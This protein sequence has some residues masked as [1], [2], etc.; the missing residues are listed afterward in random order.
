MNSSPTAAS[1]E[2]AYEAPAW[3]R[4][5]QRYTDHLVCDFLGGPRPWKFAWVINFQKAGTFV[6][7]LALIAYYDNTS[8]LGFLYS[9]AVRTWATPQDWTFNDVNTLVVH[10]RGDPVAFVETAP[11]AITISGAGEDIWDVADEFAYA[12]KSLNGD[13]T[14]IARI[15]SLIDTHVN[16]KAGLMIRENLDP[17][18]NSNS[19]SASERT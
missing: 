9:E 4:A 7:L 19:R 16:A 1:T 12:Y 15:E 10:F 18:S 6:F 13:G 14:I 11:G 5:M 2:T 3:A 17:G 8:T